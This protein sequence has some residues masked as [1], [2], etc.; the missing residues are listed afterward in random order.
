MCYL[1]QPCDEFS[2][3]S[4]VAKIHGPPQKVRRA[5]LIATHIVEMIRLIL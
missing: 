2:D 5:W 3:P 1:T 4:H